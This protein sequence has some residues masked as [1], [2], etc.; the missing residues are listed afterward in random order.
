MLMQSEVLRE[1][2]QE[3]K[4]GFEERVRVVGDRKGVSVRGNSS[5][6]QGRE[7]EFPQ[8]EAPLQNLPCLISCLCPTKLIS[9]SPLT[10][11]SQLTNIHCQTQ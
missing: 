1:E 2:V 5:D 3:K 4:S 6:D 9:S 8:C 10:L 7:W 11:S